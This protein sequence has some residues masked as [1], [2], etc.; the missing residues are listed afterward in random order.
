MKYSLWNSNCWIVSTPF[1]ETTF[2]IKLSLCPLESFFFSVSTIL[3]GVGAALASHRPFKI[4]FC[5]AFL[6]IEGM[7]TVVD[8]FSDFENFENQLMMTLYGEFY[9]QSRV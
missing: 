3:P 6:E 1:N 5:C 9:T 8:E 7:D 2:M 4:V